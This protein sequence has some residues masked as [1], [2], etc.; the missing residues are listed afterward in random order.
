MKE[1]D[2][3]RP[4]G[5]L[6]VLPLY[7]T[8]S[9]G[10]GGFLADREIASRVWLKQRALLNRGSHL[11]PLHASEL[12]GKGTPEL[13]QMRF[14]MGLAD[15]RDSLNP[16]EEK[17]WRYF[18]PRKL[19][20]FFYATNYEGQGRQ[21]DRVFFDIDRPRD[22]AHSK[23]REVTHLFLQAVSGDGEIRRLLKSEPLVAWTGSSFH[24]YLFLNQK[25]DYDFYREQIHYTE[26]TPTEGFTAN[27]INYV[28]DRT[29]VKVIGGHE[30]KPGCIT[31]DPSQTPSG[32]LARS[33]LGSLHMSDH[34]TVDGVSMPVA[35]E[36]LKDHALTESLREYT[37]ERLIKELSQ[38]SQAL[39]RRN[40]F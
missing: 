29:G 34:K 37:P 18:P 17:I 16:V 4:L 10:L 38:F 3:L 9:T 35:I 12:A 27:W 30:K 32:K 13:L 33:P 21:I 20:D 15:A 6:D 5:E 19:C 14:K 40:A 1:K 31:I 8:V 26:K 28:R 22:I 24:V 25:Q 36:R 11:P 7:S 2:V 23:A 39:L